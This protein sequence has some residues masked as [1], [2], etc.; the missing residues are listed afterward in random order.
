MKIRFFDIDWDTTEKKKAQLP[1]ECVVELNNDVNVD[2]EGLTILSE[3]YG[4]GTKVN[5]CNWQFYSEHKA[6][7]WPDHA[8]GKRESK[9]LREEHNKLY[10]AY[11]ALC[12]QV[13]KLYQ[14][15]NKELPALMQLARE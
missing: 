9:Q 15:L 4:F 14:E 5:S 6:W 13:D 11:S 3:H 8:I 2:S 7:H 12:D 1:K 10:N